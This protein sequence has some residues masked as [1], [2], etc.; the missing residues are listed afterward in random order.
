[1]PPSGRP[2][3]RTGAPAILTWTGVFG[4]SRIQVIVPV[5][6]T[7]TGWVRL[8]RAASSYR[9]LDDRRRELDGG[10]FSATLPEVLGPGETGYLVD[11]LSAS[12]SD[13]RA[14]ATTRV[15]LGS[16]PTDRPASGLTVSDLELSSGASGGLRA[17]GQVRNDGDESVPTA[18]VGVVVLDGDD[19]PAGAVYDLTDVTDLGPGSVACFDTD[20]PGAPPLDDPDAYTAVGFA[21]SATH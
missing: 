5:R 20:Y 12:F 2:V 14:I 16:A 8:P 7:G 9:L 18:L 19:R 21:F 1:M 10:V 6:N 3:V 4:E 11:T 15:S 13:P 17:V